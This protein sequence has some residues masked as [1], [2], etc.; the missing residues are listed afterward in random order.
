MNRTSV[1]KMGKCKNATKEGIGVQRDTSPTP[2]F[3]RGKPE[4]T[5]H[6]LLEEVSSQMDMSPKAPFRFTQLSRL[7]S[8][9]SLSPEG[10]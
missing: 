8:I 9:H 2:S 7:P 3:C 10:I 5:T 4:D 6:N 1:Y